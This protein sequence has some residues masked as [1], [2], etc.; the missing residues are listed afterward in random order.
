MVALSV[1]VDKYYISPLEPDGTLKY[2]LKKKTFLETNG[3]NSGTAS[4]N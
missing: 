1:Y 4:P 3:Y 2:S